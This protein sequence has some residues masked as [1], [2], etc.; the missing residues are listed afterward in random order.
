MKT[1]TIS[2]LKAS[3][4]E[5]LD[6]VR[7]GEELIVTDRGRP[8]AKIVPLTREDLYVPAHL[9]QLERQGAVRIGTGSLPDG[10]LERSRPK[11]GAGRGLKALLEEREGPR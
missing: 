1:A 8:V 5:Y 6:R 4:S 7:S 9:L 11:D 3:L 10:F 2:R